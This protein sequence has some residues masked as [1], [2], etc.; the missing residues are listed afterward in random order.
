MTDKRAIH[1][2]S[3]QEIPRKFL[4][5][6][7]RRI[8]K[9]LV[10]IPTMEDFDAN[11]HVGRAVTCAKKFRGWTN[12]L[13]AAG[14]DPG[15]SRLQVSNDDLKNEFTRIAS[16]LGRTPT[17]DEFNAHKRLGSASTL[18]QRFGNKKRPLTCKSL[19]FAVP[20]KPKPT[21]V[22]GWNKGLKSAKVNLD[23]LRHLYEEEGLSINSIAKTLG[24][25]IN[26]IRRRMDEAGISIRRHHYTQP[27]QTAPETLLYTEME[28]Q[29]IPFMKQQPIDGLYVA[30]ALVPG[31]KIIVEVDGD[32]W[33]R[34]TDQS[35]VRRDQKKSKYL[36]SRGYIV[37]RFTESELKE[38]I[39]NCV[40]KISALWAKYKHQ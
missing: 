21:V 12:F 39:A 30:D 2:L 40:E 36:E 38:D 14:F 10:K 25:G 6:E 24:F 37:F 26:T 33:H 31:A 8:A 5:D 15:S 11:S 1:P 3:N 35:I 17:S 27:R 19:G 34:K 13:I 20:I 28:R 16:L 32:Y 9:V 18:A 4:I 29:R 7:L 22:G 23:Q